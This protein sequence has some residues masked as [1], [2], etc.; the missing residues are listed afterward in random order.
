MMSLK[1]MMKG[2]MAAI[3]L[4]VIST[5]VALAQPGGRMGMNPQ[6]MAKQNAAEMAKALKLDKAQQD[7]VY[8]Y[9]LAQSEEM[10]KVIQSMMQGGDREGMRAKME[11]M[12][13]VTNDKIKAILKDDQ[14]A[15]FEKYLKEQQNRRGMMGGGGARRGGGR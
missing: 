6:E 5:T 11:E 13:K 3:V 4:F 12:Q 10:Q 15:A 2:M 7:S 14:H 9:Q 1:T 8:K